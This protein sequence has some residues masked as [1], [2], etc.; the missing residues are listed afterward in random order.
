MNYM[1]VLK[2]KA[3]KKNFKQL[4][5][6]VRNGEKT[7]EHIYES[8][9]NL[10]SP[11]T[12]YEEMKATKERLGADDGIQAFHFIQSFKPDEV[13]PEV[14]NEIG[15]EFARRYF[16]DEYEVLI[17]THTDKKHCHNHIVVNSVNRLTGKKFHSSKQDMIKYR[18]CSDVICN[19]Y[20]LSTIVRKNYKGKH[21]AEWNAEKQGKPTIRSL[22][23]ADIEKV[24][25]NSYGSCYIFERKL[26]LFGYKIK[27]GKYLSVKPPFAERFVR[28]DRMGYSQENINNRLTNW[29]PKY[30][31]PNRP[32][33]R[34]KYQGNLSNIR[35]YKT[36]WQIFNDLLADSQK[37][38]VS[39][40]AKWRHK[41][42]EEILIESLAG[43]TVGSVFLI[44]SLFITLLKLVARCAT[45]PSITG[46]LKN[47]VIKLDKYQKQFEVIKAGKT[48]DKIK[49]TAVDIIGKFEKI[50]DL[51]KEKILEKEQY[52]QEKEQDY[53][54]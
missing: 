20:G 12:A 40:G 11:K 23:K 31:Y 17:C 48:E 47:D 42:D 34:Y 14:A 46:F 3:R 22:V 49:E 37:V 15:R 2:I 25:K 53:E 16:K 38:W 18:V 24:I 33:N 35:P 4:V 21:Y 6:Y 19:E 50:Q 13:S 29:K 52:T 54:R 7:N 32:I 51:R 1:A 36:A 28:L 5:D 10:H 44:F 45:P 41:T 30:H 26:E 27:Q 8:V 43:L 9:W 39:D